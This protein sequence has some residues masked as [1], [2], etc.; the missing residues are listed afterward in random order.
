MRIEAEQ[1]NAFFDSVNLDKFRKSIQFLIKMFQNEEVRQK[2]QELKKNLFH[3][4][5]IYTKESLANNIEKKSNHFFEKNA[6]IF[7][8][9][10][11]F[12]YCVCNFNLQLTNENQP[13]M[14][15]KFENF[16]GAHRFNKS[17]HEDLELKIRD[18]KIVNLLAED[19]IERD[20]LTCV[21][22]K[23]RAEKDVAYNFVIYLNTFDVIGK[24]HNNRWKVFNNFEVITNPLIV[25]FSNEMFEVLYDFIWNSKMDSLAE[26]APEDVKLDSEL[27]ECFFAD[28]NKF[29][30]KKGEIAKKKKKIRDSKMGKD[31][32]TNLIP[33]FYRRFKFSKSV[34][35]LTYRSKN[36]LLV[37]LSETEQRRTHN[38]SV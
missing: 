29:N 31:E 9:M 36:L 21:H 2:S 11:I 28:P 34:I 15:L 35:Y 6:E 14:E 7:L 22:N 37:C 4:M 30:K 33:N 18:I 20:V 12:E 19:P 13:F 16:C 1:I 5:N 38:R 8:I 10:K 24:I 25:R 23:G 3:E 27:N 32:I 26:K 17:N